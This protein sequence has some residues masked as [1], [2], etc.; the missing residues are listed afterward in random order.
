VEELKT[1]PDEPMKNASALVAQALDAE[2]NSHSGANGAGSAQVVND[3]TSMVVKKKKKPA[4]A[5]AEAS[6]SAS[7]SP[8]KRKAEEEGESSE[9]KKVRLGEP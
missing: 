8:T 9:G 1:R 2:L 3:L 7:G 4:P 5:P 6:G